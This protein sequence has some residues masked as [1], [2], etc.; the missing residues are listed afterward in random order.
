MAPL[1]QTLRLQAGTAVTSAYI[2]PSNRSHLPIPR[3]TSNIKIYIVFFDLSL[4][5]LFRLPALAYLSK[6]I[7]FFFWGGGV[8]L[9]KN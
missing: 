2:E 8:M 5:V 7:F 3:A 4:H 6:E 1:C 9:K